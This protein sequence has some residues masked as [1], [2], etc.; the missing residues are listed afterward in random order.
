[1]SSIA[2][3]DLRL[4]LIRHGQA[5]GN[6]E[7]RFLGHRDDALTALGMDQAR[8]LGERLAEV[9]LCA[10]ITSPLQR[11]RITAASLAE[12]H[13]LKPRT[14]ERLIEQDYGLWDGL[15]FEQVVAGFGSAF[16][17]WRNLGPEASPPRGEPLTAVIARLVPLLTEIRAAY[18]EGETVALVGHAS[19]FQA[20]LCHVLGVQPR[21]RWPF[22]LKNGSITILE[23]SGGM[24]V[25]TQLSGYHA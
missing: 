8:L 21:A 3:M 16:A 12:P 6:L 18:R 23:Y 24:P 5:E 7:G 13:G 4:L 11:A 1:M 15:T 22:R 2:R 9:P 19:A 17:E 20:L 25:L 10:I 14:D